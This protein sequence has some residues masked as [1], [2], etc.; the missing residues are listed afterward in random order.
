VPATSG[1]YSTGYAY[2]GPAFDTGKPIEENWINRHNS[3]DFRNLVN[4][5]DDYRPKAG[6]YCVGQQ[7]NFMLV[8]M[9]QSA[10][11]QLNAWGIQNIQDYCESLWEPILPGL[12]ELGIHLNEKRAHHLVGIRLPQHLKA[13]Q[14]PAEL[15]KRKLTVSFR[16]DAIRV[17]PNVY[18]RTD[19]LSRLLGALQA[20]R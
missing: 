8:P 18:N 14:L 13:D 20:I 12:A 11:S 5:Q 9:Q 16:G 6:R 10:L 1:P 3:Q 4:Y 19:E 2:Y 17:A 7:S 15:A